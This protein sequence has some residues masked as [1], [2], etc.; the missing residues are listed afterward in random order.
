MVLYL[1]LLINGSLYS[2]SRLDGV[3]SYVSKPKRKKREI[4]Q[5][6][7]YFFIFIFIFIFFNNTV[8]NNN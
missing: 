2:T 3:P 4:L 6:G 1:N 7:M 5:E 8:I